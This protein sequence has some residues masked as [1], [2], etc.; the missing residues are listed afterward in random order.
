[1]KE[2]TIY[3]L[4]ETPFGPPE[5]FFAA[6]KPGLFD[7]LQQHFPEKKGLHLDFLP[8]PVV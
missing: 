5:V 4:P 2:E 3:L 7:P 1:V 8:A 6:A